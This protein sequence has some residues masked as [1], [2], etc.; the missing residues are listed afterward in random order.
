LEIRPPEIVAAQLPSVPDIKGWSAEQLIDHLQA[1]F[2][3]DLDNDDLGIL[4][5]KKSEAVHS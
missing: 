5:K 3:D 2:P 4:R 1:M